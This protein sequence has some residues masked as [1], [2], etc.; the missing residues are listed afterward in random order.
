M[1]AFFRL[2]LYWKRLLHI[3]FHI[4]PHL[5][6]ER[7]PHGEA[8]HVPASRAGWVGTAVAKQPFLA[9]VSTLVGSICGVRSGA[10]LRTPS[11][12][13]RWRLEFMTVRIPRWLIAP[14]MYQ[15]MSV[16]QFDGAREH[17]C[18]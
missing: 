5:A 16:K 14:M 1:P 13:L 8:V 17:H 18:P 6:Q 10:I 12:R 4:K 2:I 15:R 3:H 9:R 11:M 7:D